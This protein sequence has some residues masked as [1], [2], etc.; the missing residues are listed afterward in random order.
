MIITSSSH[1]FSKQKLPESAAESSVR[2]RSAPDNLP[3][4]T[5]SKTET[6]IPTWIKRELSAEFI[7]SSSTAENRLLSEISRVKKRID[8]QTL[9]FKEHEK[10]LGILHQKMSELQTLQ[11]VSAKA[12][13][14][15]PPPAYGPHTGCDKRLALKRNTFFLPDSHTKI[16]TIL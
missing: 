14:N 10:Q 1:T 2:R 3:A 15:E 9:T 11:R 7:P 16:C 5:L 6:A 4:T 8:E 13:P 12:P